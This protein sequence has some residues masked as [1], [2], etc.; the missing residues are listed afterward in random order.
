MGANIG[1]SVTNTIVAMGQLGDG[2][3]LER[4]FSAATVHDLFNFCTV[5]ILLPVEVITGYL[6]RLTGAIVKNAEPT[7]GEDWDGPL[8]K[9][10]DPLVKLIIDDNSAVVKHVAKGGSCSDFYPIECE[11]GIISDDTCSQAL[12]SCDG[13]LGCPAFFN[14]EATQSEEI[15]AGA[16]CFFLAIVILFICLGGLVYVL[17]KML[18]GA[19]SRIIYKATDVNPYIS[20]VIGAG[21]TMLVQ[22]SSITTSVLTPLAGVGVLRLENML[23]LTLGANIGTTSE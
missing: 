14:P 20:I 5:A 12:I 22:S 10:V 11:N 6:N 19:S 18:L 4:A 15:T 17:K 13:D 23:P 1:T 7:D 16:I 21:L 3:V 2:D 8:D 9:I